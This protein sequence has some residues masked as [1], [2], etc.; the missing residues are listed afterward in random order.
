MV[1]GLIVWLHSVVVKPGS[2]KK[3]RKPWL[4]KEKI[5]GEGSHPGMR[6][7][8]TWNF[9]PIRSRTHESWRLPTGS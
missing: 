5:G 2:R 4:H 9:R 8:K 7:Y 6:D 1:V 3:E